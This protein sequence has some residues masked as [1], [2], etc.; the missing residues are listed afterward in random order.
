MSKKTEKKKDFFWLSYSDLMTSLFFVMLVLFILVYS[1]QQS[2]IGELN[3]Y[4]EEYL[5]IKEMIESKEKL[6]IGDFQNMQNDVVSQYAGL[7]LSVILPYIDSA[8][9]LNP[10]ELEVLQILKEWDNEMLPDKMAP[11]IFETWTNVF[12]A[13]PH[14]FALTN[15]LI[16]NFHLP[17]TS[18]LIMVAAFMGYDLTMEAYKVAIKN[19]YRFFSYGD[20]MLII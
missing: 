1:I 12:I 11:T 2:V 4:K 17:K 9:Y 10:K 13:P 7:F 16:T 14:D 20:A 18:L 5:R 8:N 6:S 15:S 3:V 19:K